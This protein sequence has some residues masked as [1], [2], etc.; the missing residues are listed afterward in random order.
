MKRVFIILLLLP[1]FFCKAYAETPEEQAMRLFDTTQMEAGMQEDEL[2]I[3]GSV[4]PKNYDVSSALSRLWRSFLNR[5]REEART[6]FGFAGKM[7]ALVF[8][9]AFA[10][11]VC[12]EDKIRDMIEICAVC[13]AAV[14]LTGSLDSLVAQTTQ[15][16]Y[17]L[18]DY[19][20]A[21]LPVVY[22]AAAASGGVS[23]AALGYAG[24]CLALDVMMSLSQQAVLPLIYASLSLTLANVVFPNPMLAAIEKLFK[25][26]AKTVLTGATIAFTAYLGMSSLI[27][28]RFDA[29]AIKATRTVISS[30]LPVVGGMLSDASSAVLSAAAVVLSCTGVFGLI[31]VCAMCAAPFAVLSVKGLLFRAVA[32]I[33]EA[34]HSPQ[35]QRL[36]S[37]VGG[38]VGL[39]MGLLG[40][41]AIMLFLSFAAAIKVVSA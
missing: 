37:G 27:S 39:L 25:W 30:T 18:S 28:T 10:C 20:K 24:A 9:C 8:L 1:A 29:A 23:S 7:L 15:A 36:F 16:V 35:L 12:E 19:S 31:A 38:A 22:T 33:A 32:V 5:L 13:A 17:R 21:A 4:T 6:S 14:F 3:S 41:N 34:V 2:A 40:C 11:S 26:A